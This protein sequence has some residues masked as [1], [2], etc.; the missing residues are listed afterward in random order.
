MEHDG[1]EKSF[2]TAYTCIE[3]RTPSI[4]VF[5]GKDQSNISVIV[6]QLCFRVYRLVQ[7]HVF[8]TLHISFSTYNEILCNI[9]LKEAP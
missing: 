4:D 1:N 9:T 2:Q 7:R 3:L 8:G 6:L 5:D